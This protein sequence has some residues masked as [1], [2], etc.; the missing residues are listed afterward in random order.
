MSWRTRKDGRHFQSKGKGMTNNSFKTLASQD[1]ARTVFF[2]QGVGRP[3]GVQKEPEG[4]PKFANGDRV[5]VNAEVV[6]F[7]NPGDRA[8]KLKNEPAIVVSNMTDFPMSGKTYNVI[9]VRFIKYPN[10]EVHFKAKDVSK[11]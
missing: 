9:R 8:K 2:S 5:K 7:P 6:N 1:S 4:T 3:I 11:I 10:K